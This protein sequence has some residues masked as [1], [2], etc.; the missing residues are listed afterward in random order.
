MDGCTNTR[1]FLRIVVPLSP[2]IISIIAL[3][4]VVGCRN[5][6]VYALMFIDTQGKHPLQ[7]VLRQI[8]VLGGSPV[9]SEAS[10]Y[11]SPGY[12]GRLDQGPRTF[13][14]AQCLCYGHT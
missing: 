5:A 2:A 12:H 6:Y 10:S 11:L 4:N 8:L 9:S 3:F 14:G 13:C 7:L 1:F